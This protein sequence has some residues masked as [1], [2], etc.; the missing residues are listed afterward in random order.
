MGQI[1][2]FAGQIGDSVILLY[3]AALSAADLRSRRIKGA[4]LLFGMIFT[5]G[6]GMWLNSV[7]VILRATGVAAGLCFLCVSRVTGEALGYADS[8]LIGILGSYLGIWRLTEVLLFAW[9]G[10][11]LVAGVGMTRG[12]WTRK[13]TLPAV[14]FLL[15]G[16]ILLLFGERM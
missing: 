14:P 3:L 10:L 7:S 5:A 6:Y 2:I 16:Y 11:A 4:A 12:R 8:W 15:A 13:K 1:G 9:S